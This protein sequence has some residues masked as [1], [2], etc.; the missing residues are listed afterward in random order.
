MQRYS[1]P[2]DVALRPKYSP[3]YPPPPRTPPDQANDV[4]GTHRC[5]LGTWRGLP[6]GPRCLKSSASPSPTVQTHLH[7]VV[8][9][10]G[11]CRSIQPLSPDC[12][13]N[14]AWPTVPMSSPGPQRQQLTAKSSPRDLLALGRVRGCLCLCQVSIRARIGNRAR[15]AQIEVSG[16]PPTPAP[17]DGARQSPD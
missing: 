6:S 15:M 14:P 8:P 9:C 4:P 3:R 11:R 17:A 5:S 12:V 13:P 2:R 10:M 16:N 7:Q 1:I